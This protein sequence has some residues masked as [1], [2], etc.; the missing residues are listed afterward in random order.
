M[1][2]VQG[3]QLRPHSSVRGLGMGF[4]GFFPLAWGVPGREV[5]VVAWEPQALRP[6]SVCPTAPPV[7][8]P[9]LAELENYMGLALS[10]KELQKNLLPE[11]STVGVGAGGSPCPVRVPMSQHH[12][13]G[14]NSGAPSC[15]G[16]VPASPEG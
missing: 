12:W 13:E 7:L 16:K 10:S 9:N 5:M 1:V 8:Y 11:G 6:L 2:T 14:G 3:A 4:G 15:L